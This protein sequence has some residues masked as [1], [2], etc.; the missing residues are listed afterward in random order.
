MTN[1]PVTT[2]PP[3]TPTLPLSK[4]LA[5]FKFFSKASLVLSVVN[6][7]TSGLGLFSIFGLLVSAASLQAANPTKANVRVLKLFSCC[8]L[9][10]LV[11]ALVAFM[12]AT[13]FITPVL[14]CACSDTCVDRA[15]NLLKTNINPWLRNQTIEHDVFHPPMNRR[16]QFSGLETQDVDQEDS[17]VVYSR[18]V[19]RHR[20]PSIALLGRFIMDHTNPC[21]VRSSEDPFYTHHFDRVQASIN[22]V[23]EEGEPS[24]PILNVKTIDETNVPRRATRLRIFS[25]PRLL[26]GLKEP[27]IGRYNNLYNNQEEE[28]EEE[29][30]ELWRIAASTLMKPSVQFA[31][32]NLGRFISRPPPRQQ[33]H[34]LDREHFDYFAPPPPPPPSLVNCQFMVFSRS[35]LSSSTVPVPSSSPSP[36]PSPS[37][38]PSP[39]PLPRFENPLASDNLIQRFNAWVSNLAQNNAAIWGTKSY[40]TSKKGEEE[41]TT[42][43]LLG[44][45]LSS[46]RL[47]RKVSE[48]EDNNDEEEKEATSQRRKRSPPPSKEIVLG[49]W[50]T[51]HML[52]MTEA[53]FID[54]ADGLC[55]KG[56]AYYGL[57]CVPFIAWIAFLR[58]ARLKAMMLFK[59]S[60][61]IA[62]DLSRR[63]RRR[64]EIQTSS[65]SSSQ[66]SSSSSSISTTPPSLPLGTDQSSEPLYRFVQG[67]GFV[68][69]TNNTVT[70]PIQ[71]SQ[72]SPAIS[73]QQIIPSAPPAAVDTQEDPG[74][75]D[76]RGDVNDAFRSIFDPVRDVFS[77][78]GNSNN[79]YSRV[80]TVE[81][82]E[83]ANTQ[84]QQQPQIVHQP[85][86]ERYT[87]AAPTP[88]PQSPPL[89]VQ[90]YPQF[91]SV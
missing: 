49:Q 39:S 87:D 11:L 51:R 23:Q 71:D 60:E 2:T 72:G 40:I 48:K 34:E 29:R 42:T 43:T 57:A 35:S 68:M 52:N 65:S 5:D 90:R 86:Q 75:G 78:W 33:W 89:G 30:P 21:F 17:E 20:L 77:R 38:S 1:P 8:Q 66:P 74:A 79:D 10:N 25:F 59:H 22:L 70:A 28:E 91:P 53:E 9:F 58:M 31:L 69:V 32:H 61:Y 64:Q 12:V 88:Y 54:R 80:Q 14:S 62:A 37:A 7:F 19:H 26:L 63:R 44:D 18:H 84:M 13:V 27:S 3:T 6:L 4:A 81:H 67:V 82:P 55:N 24:L 83:D 50:I 46:Q 16:L 85:N 45:S 36:S 56:W 15:Y 47:L 41:E 76:L 73:T